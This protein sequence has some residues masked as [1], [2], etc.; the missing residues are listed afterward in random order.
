MTNNEI[1][2][3]DNILNMDNYIGNVCE[4]VEEKYG[5]HSEYNNDT[6]TIQLNE[7]DNLRL[8]AAKNY[9]LSKIDTNLIDIVC[10]K[11]A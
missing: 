10:N 9:I 6:N 11:K 3:V 8:S 5:V 7:S 4:Q 2:F 1:G